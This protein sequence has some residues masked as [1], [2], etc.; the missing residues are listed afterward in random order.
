MVSG[1]GE[2]KVAKIPNCAENCGINLNLYYRLLNVLDTSQIP[3]FPKEIVVGW[4]GVNGTLDES[5]LSSEELKTL[6][7][8]TNEQRR[9]EF[10]TARHVFWKLIEILGWEATS[11]ILKK[12]DTGKP[13]IESEKGIRYVSFSHSQDLVLCA[14]S[15]SLDI[16]L[17]AETLNRQVNS[18]IV[19]RILNENEWKIYGEDDPVS[20]WTMKE[21]AVKS[22]GTG[23]RTNL[24]DLELEKMENGHFNITINGKEELH[25]VC[26]K[27]LN[28]YISIAY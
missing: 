26:F 5:I 19:K 22:L 3:G 18:A 13:F 23:L 27:A 21:A 2:S 17:D 12:E 9:G 6:Q 28:H 10:I 25:G 14:V 1:F 8:F 11:I 7:T 4:S 16:G 24:K 15:G 20:L